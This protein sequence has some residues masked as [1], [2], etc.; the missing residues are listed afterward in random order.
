[1]RGVAA[2]QKFETDLPVH[3]IGVRLMRDDGE[4]AAR[5]DDPVSGGMRLGLD[6]QAEFAGRDVT[7]NDGEGA[8]G[9]QVV[10]PSHSRPGDSK[11]KQDQ[12]EYFT[13]RSG[14]VP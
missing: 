4:P 3:G 11:R 7:R 5:R 1:M 10:V 13:H 2:L 14:T 9:E 6:R 12:Q 8:V